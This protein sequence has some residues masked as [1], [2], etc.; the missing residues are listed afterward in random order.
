[1]TKYIA[2]GMAILG[3]LFVIDTIDEI[4]VMVKKKQGDNPISD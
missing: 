4:V 3:V 2:W 1:M